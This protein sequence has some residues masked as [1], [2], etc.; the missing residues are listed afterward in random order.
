MNVLSIISIVIMLLGLAYAARKRILI[1]QMIVVIN[2][3]IFFML[4]FTSHHFSTVYSPIFSDLA[5]RPAYLNGVSRLYTLFTSMF[6]HADIFHILMNMLIF[7][8][9]GIPF[10]QRVG[11]R[12][13]AAVYFIS[14]IFG[15]IFFSIFNWGSNTMLVGASG[16][17]FGVFGAF[18]S[19]YPRDK[20]V[21]PIPLPIM[22]FVRM[23]VIVATIMF[24]S[25]ESLYALSSMSDGVAH[26]A[27]IG[28]LVSGIAL[29]FFIKK[30]EKVAPA[31]NFNVL[32]RMIT[33]EKQREAF[34][35]VKKA[36]VP[37]VREAWLSYLLKDM[38]CPKCGGKLVRDKGIYCRD[39]GYRL[40]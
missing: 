30:E 25:I 11:S 16:A 18:A 1:S 24:A 8:L 5:F 31:I 6:I 26:L 27:H 9:I 13:F 29:S 37:E 32:E 19:L 40:M 22:L 2:F 33:D 15:A 4:I 12:K 28:G 14:G 36:D 23:P 38:K 20:V 17:I 3:V 35:R 7:L 10:E 34:E 21:M 39:C